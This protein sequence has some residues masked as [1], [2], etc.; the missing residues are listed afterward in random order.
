[1]K[2]GTQQKAKPYKEQMELE[3]IISDIGDAMRRA[4]LRYVAESDRLTPAIEWAL[5][6]FKWYAMKVSAVRREN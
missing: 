5:Q 3:H 1:M 6:R 2:I 4:H